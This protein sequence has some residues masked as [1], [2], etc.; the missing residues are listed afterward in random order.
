M[1]KN[2]L[3]LTA[4]VAAG[5]LLGLVPA[6]AWAP[7]NFEATE[8]DCENPCINSFEIEDGAVVADDLA[9]DAVE[10]AEIKDGEVMTADL[11]DDAVT[12]AKLA[13]D[14]VDTAQIL[15]GAVTAAKLGFDPVALQR[16]IY[17]SGGDTEANNGMALLDA[18]AEIGTSGPCADMPTADLPCLVKLGPGVFDVGS[19]SIGTIAFVDFEGSGQTVTTI[20]GDSIPSVVQLIGGDMEIRNLTVEYHGQAENPANSAIGIRGSATN[21]RLSHMTARAVSTDDTNFQAAVGIVISAESTATLTDVVATADGGGGSTGIR[22]EGEAEVEMYQ[23]RATGNN[24]GLFVQYM[25][26]VIAHDSVFEGPT[27][28]VSV[29]GNDVAE[30]ATADIHHSRLIG[31][32]RA[33]P[34]S[35]S[36]RLSIAT[37]QVDA[38]TVQED[39]IIDCVYTYDDAYMELDGDCLTPP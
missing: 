17:V 36:T 7:P 26:S 29:G 30:E 8:V 27:W 21:V 34:T 25:A 38:S 24:N 33:G 3:S 23:V 16:V 19:T 15:D 10:T 9:T 22:V 13:D 28:S 1:N 31:N 6:P 39:S 35:S 12:N 32:I 18:I 5:F 4:F 14:A 2:L 11:A 20:T 37:S